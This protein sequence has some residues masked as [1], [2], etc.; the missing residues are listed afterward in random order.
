M[1]S[2]QKFFEKKSA[3]VSP[4]FALI[5]ATVVTRKSGLNVV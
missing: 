5:P 1:S 3:D 4:S 2:A